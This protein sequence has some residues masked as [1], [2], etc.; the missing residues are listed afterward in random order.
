M[1]RDLG[2]PFGTE[3]NASIDVQFLRTATRLAR[4]AGYSFHK[5]R[6]IRAF[7]LITTLSRVGIR[8]PSGGRNE[9]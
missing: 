1:L 2:P 6:S 5:Q 3:D 9:I 4:R 8:S 7:L